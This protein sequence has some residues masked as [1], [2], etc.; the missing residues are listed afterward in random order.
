[1]PFEFTTTKQSAESNGLKILVYGPAGAGKT[2]TIATMPPEWRPLIISAERGMLSLADQELSVVETKTFAQV[3]E[4]YSYLT[5][6]EARKYFNTV[7][8]DSISDIAESCLVEEKKKVNDPRQ[9]YGAMGDSIIDI[10]KKFRDLPYNVY[11]TA[12]Q[13]KDKDQNGIMM[14]MPNAPG[15]QVGNALPYLFDEVFALVNSTSEDGS[16]L[17]WYLTNRTRTHEAKDRSGALAL[18]EPY[19]P[20]SL[21]GLKEIVWKIKAKNNQN[22]VN[23]DIQD[24]QVQG[25]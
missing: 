11:M 1:M 12:K 20:V 15:G 10:V 19:D 8:I 2:R 25:N 14:Y 4:V 21:I 18:Y 24:T 16:L 7:C 6:S 3:N 13:E 22:Q 17:T 9:A 23:Q 5:T